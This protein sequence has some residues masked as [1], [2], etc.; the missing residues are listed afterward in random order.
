M[1]NI[2]IEF[3][4]DVL[5]RM[6][7]PCGMPASDR[8]VMEIVKRVM[9]VKRLELLQYLDSPDVLYEKIVNKYEKAPTM[10]TI[11]RPAMLF[12]GNLTQSER[13]DLGLIRPDTDAVQER[14]ISLSSQ[15][16]ALRKQQGYGRLKC[17]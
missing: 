16:T 7:R 2:T 13:E 3:V 11:L 14:Y 8:T 17:V 15:V 6:K 12:Y 10:L 4:T 9:N 5:R 1:E